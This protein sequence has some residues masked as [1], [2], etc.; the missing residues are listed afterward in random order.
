MTH[1]GNGETEGDDSEFEHVFR[2]LCNREGD[3]VENTAA[4]VNVKFKCS[5]FES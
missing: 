3:G 1:H 4:W 2:K 5:P